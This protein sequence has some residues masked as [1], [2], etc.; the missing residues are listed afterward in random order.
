[1]NRE[2][3][4][5][6]WNMDEIPACDKGMELAQAFLVSAGEAV[7]RLGTEEPGDRI[8]ELTAAYTAMTEHFSG[9]ENC[10]ENAHQPLRFVASE[11]GL[12]VTVVAIRARSNQP[13]PACIASTP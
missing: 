6:L 4:L 2:I 3:L 5:K 11:T 9:C 8:I 1:M 10:N 12:P 13:Y 7:Y